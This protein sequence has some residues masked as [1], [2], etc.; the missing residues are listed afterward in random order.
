MQEQHRGASFTGR[1]VLRSSR[2]TSWFAVETGVGIDGDML[3]FRV[4]GVHPVDSRVSYTFNGVL[5]RLFHVR[6]VR[7]HLFSLLARPPR[8]RIAGLRRQRHLR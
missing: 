3:T 7:R 4:T 8:V 6:R 2:A 1:A 5:G